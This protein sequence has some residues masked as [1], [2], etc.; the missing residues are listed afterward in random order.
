MLEK[1]LEKKLTTIIKKHGGQCWKLTSPG[2]AGVPD[3]IAIL[4]NG[5]TIFIELKA[6]NKKPR[7]LQTRQQQKLK[8]LGH[9]TLTIN[10][11]DQIQKLDQELE[12]ELKQE[13]DN[14]L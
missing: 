8:N 11:P 5:K 6:P 1:N 14:A 3:R 4:P 7:P 2:T 10:H 9:H 13:P 12:Q